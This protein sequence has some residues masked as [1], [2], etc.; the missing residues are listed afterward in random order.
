[1]RV[2]KTWVDSLQRVSL[3]SRLCFVGKLLR[4]V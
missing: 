2:N 3:E 4:V 1:M